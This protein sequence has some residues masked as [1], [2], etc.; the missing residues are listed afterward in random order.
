MFRVHKLYYVISINMII[1]G[2]IMLV[3]EYFSCTYIGENRHSL[4]QEYTYRQ[5]DAA[6]EY[7][8]C[9]K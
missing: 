2:T 9:L 8:K 4:I 3:T 7:V 5:D 6:S 1:C